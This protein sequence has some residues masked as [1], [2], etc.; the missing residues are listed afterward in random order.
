MLVSFRFE[1]E[2]EDEMDAIFSFVNTQQR[3]EL[4]AEKRKRRRGT[5]F[6]G[7]KRGE[8]KKHKQ[9]GGE[10]GPEANCGRF[11]LLCTHSPYS[12]S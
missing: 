10:Q 7:E 6:G 5:P 3:L 2:E 12:S 9:R 8:M 11:P 4:G 1:K